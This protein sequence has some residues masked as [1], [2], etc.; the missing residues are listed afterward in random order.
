MASILAFGTFFGTKSAHASI[1]TTAD[2]SAQTSNLVVVVGRFES[3]T[4]NESGCTNWQLTLDTGWCA[5]YSGQTYGFASGSADCYGK[6]LAVILG[7]GGDSFAPVPTGSTVTCDPLTRLRP[8]ADAALGNPSLYV[9]GGAGVDQ[10]IGGPGDDFLYSNRFLPG[11]FG[12]PPS[13]PA[14]SAIDCVCGM[15]GSD[16]VGGD[17]D[18]SYTYRECLIGGSQTDVCE[19]GLGSTSPYYDWAHS[20]CETQNRTTSSQPTVCS[21]ALVTMC[22]ASQPPSIW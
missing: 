18:D 12:G 4:C 15:Q 13:T 17:D 3:R 5:K 6:T 14:D 8:F 20:S 11:L 16:W 19:G 10:V 1:C 21:S 7:S 22:T 2:L 9:Q